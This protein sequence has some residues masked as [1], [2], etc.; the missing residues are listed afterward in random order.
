MMQV[1]DCCVTPDENY[2]RAIACRLCSIGFVLRSIPDG[3]LAV[4]IVPSCDLWAIPTS[5]N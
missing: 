2:A 1:A 5:R 3:S 4:G